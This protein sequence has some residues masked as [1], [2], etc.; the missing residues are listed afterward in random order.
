MC[1]TVRLNGN[2]GEKKRVNIVYPHTHTA[3]DRNV[4]MA[5]ESGLDRWPGQSVPAPTPSQ[6][7]EFYK[8]K[9]GK[10]LQ[11][12]LRMCRIQTVHSE[13]TSL[14]IAFL[15]NKHVDGRS[16]TGRKHYLV[17]SQNQKHWAAGSWRCSSPSKRPWLPGST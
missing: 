16:A 10:K 4:A 9:G 6:Q 3:Q 14:I 12:K 1:C 8:G 7:T 5:P 13:H 15:N 17:V 11:I 2:D